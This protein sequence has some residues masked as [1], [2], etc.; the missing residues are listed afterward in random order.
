MPRL[1]RQLHTTGK[2]KI[3]IDTPTS[4]TS[5]VAEWPG[6]HA[7]LCTITIETMRAIFE[8]MGKRDVRWERT[9]CV[10]KHGGTECVTKL[11]WR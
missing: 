10:S 6:H 2:R 11:T 7:V 8:R 9:R 5:I 1:W 3:T 4:A